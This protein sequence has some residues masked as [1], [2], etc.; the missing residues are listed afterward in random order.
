MTLMLL[1][2]SILTAASSCWLLAR[3]TWAQS[4]LFLPGKDDVKFLLLEGGKNRPFSLKGCR[5]RERRLLGRAAAGALLTA[6]SKK[7]KGTE[8]FLVETPWCCL[9][10]E[11]DDDDDIFKECLLGLG[12][13]ERTRKGEEWRLIS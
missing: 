4:T 13:E 5:G 2:S 7:A 8:F 3:I 9:R 6:E 11:N 10:W 12:G 1:F